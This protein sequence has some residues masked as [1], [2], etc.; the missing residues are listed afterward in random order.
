MT[1]LQTLEQIASCVAGYDPNALPVEQAQE[2]IARLVPRV[3][4][5]ESVALRSSL[6]R[7][8]ARDIVSAI[9]VPAHDNSAM[10]GY[11]LRGGDLVVGSDTVLRV[12]G[13]GLAG[14]A[15]GGD[16]PPGH[17][18]RIMTGAVMPAGLDTVVPQEFTLAAHVANDYFDAVGGFWRRRKS[19]LV[20]LKQSFSL[21]GTHVYL[22]LLGW[23]FFCDH[24][25]IPLCICAVI[26]KFLIPAFLSIIGGNRHA[27]NRITVCRAHIPVNRPA[28]ARIRL[29]C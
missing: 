2:F 28:F 29:R 12:A 6:G 14:Q 20:G 4:A 15:F 23:K 26:A 13:T 1:K 21:R 24:R 25:K 22:Q 7:V 11:A 9:D 16:V 18:V 19:H 10:D 8:L 5:I 27:L 3:T 17:C